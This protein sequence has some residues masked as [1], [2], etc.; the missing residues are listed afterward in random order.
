MIDARRGVGT[1]VG[2]AK[3]GPKIIKQYDSKVR[4]T[5]SHANSYIILMRLSLK[6][7]GKQ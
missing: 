4:E 2:L 7:V 1:L 5:I 3:N 6:N